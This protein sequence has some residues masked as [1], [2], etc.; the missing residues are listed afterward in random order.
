MQVSVTTL[1]EEAMEKRDYR[2]SI[3][4]HID[5]VLKLSF[6]DGEPEDNNLSRNFNDV[7]KIADLLSKAYRAGRLNEQFGIEEREVDE[8]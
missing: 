5:G 4:I 1:T 6:F 8:M 7:Y 3:S 2:D